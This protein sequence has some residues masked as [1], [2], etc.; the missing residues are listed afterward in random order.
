LCSHFHDNV[1]VVEE[2]QTINK[3]LEDI[4]E[5][6]DNASRDHQKYSND[7]NTYQS[8]LANLQA[9][10]DAKYELIHKLCHDLSKI[11]S[12]FNF[13][14][15]L[16]ANIESMKQDARTIQ[17]MNVRNNAE[18]EIKRLEKLANDLS[19]KRGGLFS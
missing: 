5:Q 9:A 17:N 4:K 18:A 12:R 11:C 8:S 15:E 10:A 14:D 13:V 3:V 16:H 19:S 1:T 7:A 2:T 6:Y